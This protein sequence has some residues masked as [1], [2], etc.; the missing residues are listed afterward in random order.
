MR[1]QT[2]AVGLGTM[3]CACGLLL[4]NA[5]VFY[6][7]ETD[8]GA[9]AVSE[10]N[11]GGADG[12]SS[13]SD[14]GSDGGGVV[15]CD[16]DTERDPKHCGACGRD[17]L[18]T[19]CNEGRCAPFLL[20]A[21]AKGS[22]SLAVDDTHLYWE[23]STEI[24][25][26]DKRGSGSD[27]RACVS[28]DAGV[29]GNSGGETPGG[30]AVDDQN[31]YWR[32]GAVAVGRDSIRR[33]GKAGCVQSS[34]VADNVTRSGPPVAFGGRVYFRETA[35]IVSAPRGGPASLDG[36]FPLEPLVTGLSNNAS[37]L[38]VDPSGLY[39]VFAGGS[40][41]VITRVAFDGG[42]RT[43]FGAPGD[44]TFAL[45][46]DAIIAADLNVVRLGK[47]GGGGLTLAVANPDAGI[48]MPINVVVDATH[49]YWVDVQTASIWRS[50]LGQPRP[51]RLYQGPLAGGSTALAVDNV[52][53]YWTEP[54]PG[55]IYRLVK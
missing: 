9:D 20:S 36:G 18:G 33:C 52:A 1:K 43:T 23:T 7:P 38:A 34:F 10:Q 31:I 6:V 37:E 28:A 5:D 41:D 4:D 13:I 53:L 11:G 27:A 48:V 50:P 42:G 12:G 45:T 24:M 3:L 30:L 29:V 19:A 54:G 16:A 8:A 55:R 26:V 35:R 49:A 2:W 14:A 39:F 51:E 22:N 40:G 44:Y 32:S 17:C 25:C 47:D 46:P 15:I 21:N